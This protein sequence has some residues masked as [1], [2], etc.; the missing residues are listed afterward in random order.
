MNKMARVCMYFP[1]EGIYR[2]DC[3]QFGFHDSRA[4]VCICLLSSGLFHPPT[5]EVLITSMR[6]VRKKSM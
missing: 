1:K 5:S 2:A 4:C 3:V 6:D